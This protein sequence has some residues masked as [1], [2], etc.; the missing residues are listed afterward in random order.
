MASPT[1]Y[2]VTLWGSDPEFE[3][4]DCWTGE[5]FAT[6]AEAEAA[7]TDPDSAF[8]SYR[9]DRDVVFIELDG[10]YAHKSRRLRPDRKSPTRDDWKR[11]AAMQAGMAFGCD[12]YNDE[13]GY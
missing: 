11:E 8:P 5:D 7:F 2:S 10:P 4:D 13:M 3:N 12:G 6:L 1:S 9:G